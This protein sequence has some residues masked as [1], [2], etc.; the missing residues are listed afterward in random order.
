MND[1]ATRTGTLTF[2][3]DP[4]SPPGMA[5]P[6]EILRLA[7]PGAK[8]RQNKSLLLYLHVP[9]CSSKC[10]FC[11]WVVGYDTADLVNTGELRTKYVDALCEQIAEYGP[12]LGDLGYRV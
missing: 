11:D 2:P 8:A 7:G 3:A 1:T 10:H 12:M 9:F 6:D 5:G 4:P